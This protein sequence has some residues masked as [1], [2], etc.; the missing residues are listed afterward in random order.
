MTAHYGVVHMTVQ[1]A[2]QELKHDGLI[3]SV[4]GKGTY[5]HP[6]VRFRPEQ[7][8]E[9][10]EPALIDSE[11][12]YYAYRGRVIDWIE[13]WMLDV[14]LA[15]EREDLEA[16]AVAKWAFFD[17]LALVVSEIND[18][19][20]YERSYPDREELVKHEI[21]R[22]RPYP[23]NYARDRMEGTVKTPEQIDA[24]YAELAAAE[25]AEN[26]KPNRSRT[27]RG[28]EVDQR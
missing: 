26:P 28:K 12:L 8:G 27:M 22:L 2:V 14:H 9:A 20:R 11:L 1:R 18:L 15:A 25:K 21:I 3:F 17:Q 23:G 13:A 24:Y 7:V 4:Q 5:V 6:G 16:E 10:R 19:V